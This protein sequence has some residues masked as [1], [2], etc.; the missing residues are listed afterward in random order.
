MLHSTSSRLAAFA[1]GLA[2]LGGAAAGVGAAT[3]AT[4]PLQDSLA[5]AAADAGNGAAEPMTDGAKKMV[6]AVPGADGLHAELAG[7]R[8]VPAP[9]T[10]T[11]GGTSHWRFRIAGRRGGAPQGVG[12]GEGQVPP[13]V[14]GPPH[15]TRLPPPHPPPP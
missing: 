11:A 15:L 5:V 13:P 4:P 12:A 8:L 1:A 14:V 3:D 6:E 9:T 10:F 2:I 7:V